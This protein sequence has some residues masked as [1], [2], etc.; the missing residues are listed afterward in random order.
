MFAIAKR[1][2]HPEHH[3]H[4]PNPRRTAARRTSIT[5]PTTGVRYDRRLGLAAASMGSGELTSAPRPEDPRPGARRARP[6]T[7]SR[8][9]PTRAARQTRRRSRRRRRQAARRRLMNPALRD[10]PPSAALRRA[11]SFPAG[12]GAA[13]ERVRARVYRKRAT[14]PDVGQCR[15]PAWSARHGP[16]RPARTSG[17]A[18]VP[19][20]HL[21]SARGRSARATAAPQRGRANVEHARANT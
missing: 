3:R 15:L 21:P 12:C 18:R 8:A 5:P 6:A 10:R 13:H 1:R 14:Q 16:S 9:V 2:H 11:P 19:R 20:R 4:L 17:T 7:R